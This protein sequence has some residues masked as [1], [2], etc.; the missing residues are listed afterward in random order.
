MIKGA[1]DHVAGA[2]GGWAASLTSARG[3]R[4]EPG[5]VMMDW[6]SPRLRG[7]AAAHSLEA[8]RERPAR[9]DRCGLTGSWREPAAVVPHLMM[10][11]PVPPVSAPS[12]ITWRRSHR[13]E[14]VVTELGEQVACLPDD[15]AGFGQGGALAVDAVLDLRV[16][17]VVGR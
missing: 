15:L 12:V 5:H 17:G 4:P 14:G 8:V 16:A 7:D 6:V 11:V 13:G 9:Q 2:A 10:T 1:G 3:L